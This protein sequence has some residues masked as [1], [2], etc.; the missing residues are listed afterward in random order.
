MAQGEQIQRHW[1]LLRM[2]QT[3]GEGRPLAQLATDLGVSERTIQR[4]LEMLEELGVP[5]DFDEDEYGKRFWRVPPSFFRTGAVSLSVTEAIS[6]HLARR[7][8]DPLK[9]TP[10][11]EGLDSVLQKINSLIP[12]KARD[13]FGSLSSMIIVRPL[14]ATDYSQHTQQIRIIDQ[15]IREGITVQISYRSL[16][17]QQQYETHFDPYGLVLHLDD[18]FLVG[19][20]HRANDLRVFKISRILGVQTTRAHF[21]RPAGFDLEALFASSFGIVRSDRTPVRVSVRFSGPAAQMVEERIWHDSQRLQWLP[22][23][24]TLFE[25]DQR[26]EDTAADDHEALVAT[27]ELADLA[28]FKRWLKGFGDQAVILSPDWFR[29]EVREELLKAAAR[30]A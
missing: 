26:P 22:A 17:R 5:I 14:A 27:F 1:N 25:R 30:Y 16:W 29:N 8:F 15:A 6:L 21:E 18:L 23:E 19:R 24:Q 10:F 3:E 28:E 20:S 11:A 4:D 9:G 12:Q 2:L 7:S 13:Y